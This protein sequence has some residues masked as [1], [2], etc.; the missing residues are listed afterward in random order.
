[1]ATKGVGFEKRCIRGGRPDAG[2]TCQKCKKA[3]LIERTNRFGKTFY[4]CDDYPKCKYVVNYP[5]VQENCPDCNWAILVK[6]KMASGDVLVCPEK[7]CAYK[8]K[9][10]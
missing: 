4:S 10:I 1:M 5:P 8:R 3:E 2:V 6:R 9:D 7:K